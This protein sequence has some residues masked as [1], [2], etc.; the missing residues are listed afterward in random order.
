ME[1]EFVIGYA[2]G[3]SRGNPGLA[4]Y[5]G[6]LKRGEELLC[7]VS[8]TIGHATNNVAEYTGLVKV[9]EKA[10]ELGYTHLEMRMD[11]ELAVKQMLGV[12][13]VKNEGLI[14]LFNQAKA[15]SRKFTIFKIV[16]VRREFNKEADKL[17]NEAMDQAARQASV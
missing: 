2:D 15:L 17:A 12:Y 11:S 3:G 9:L 13:R 1:N 6:L 16:H 10:L 8:G 5:G 14:P 7:T 4:G